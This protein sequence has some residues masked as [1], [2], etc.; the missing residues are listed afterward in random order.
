MLAHYVEYRRTITRYRLAQILAIDHDG[1][2]LQD[3][4]A[5]IR[6]PAAKMTPL[7]GL[8]PLTLPPVL[9]TIRS[10]EAQKFRDPLMQSDQGN[11]ARLYRFFSRLITF[12]EDYL[13][14]AL[15]PFPARAYLTLPDLASVVPQMLFKGREV[16]IKPVAFGAMS[17]PERFRL[18]KAFVRYELLCKVYHPKIWKFL[19]RDRYANII[20]RSNQN[21]TLKDCEALC[22]VHEY[23]KGFYGALYAHCR[24]SWLPDRQSRSNLSTVADDQTVELEHQNLPSSKDYGLLYPDNVYFN[25]R[26]ARSPQRHTH[27]LQIR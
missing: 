5:V 21:L 16:D 14:K 11:I 24:D 27:V 13:A 1:T 12:I 15:D 7:W 8:S 20:E 6:L 17:K 22:C 4:L 26:E 2:I 25:A 3:A 9:R 19:K 10:W 23:F 18:L